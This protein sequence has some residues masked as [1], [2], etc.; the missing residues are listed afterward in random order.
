[1][2][3]PRIKEEHD[4]TSKSLRIRTARL[5]RYFCFLGILSFDTS[6]SSEIE[7]VYVYEKGA[8]HV[9]SCTSVQGQSWFNG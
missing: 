4:Q 6:I 3:G 1:M 2:S 9:H 7:R 8:P 5:L